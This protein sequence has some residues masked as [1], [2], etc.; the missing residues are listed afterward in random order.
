[1][2]GVT[3]KITVLSL[4]NI[5]AG[6]DACTSI[7]T[8]ASAGRKEV[9]VLI[10]DGEPDSV[11]LADEA[12][13]NAKNQEITIV[14]VGVGDVDQ[15]NLNKWSSSDPNGDPLSYKVEE[16]DELNMDLVDQIVMSKVC[17]G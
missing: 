6:I 14:T 8:G 4:I 16:F 10:T 3:L 2:K 13:E 11:T 17:V 9:M 12:A 7:L 5:A 1:L 15:A